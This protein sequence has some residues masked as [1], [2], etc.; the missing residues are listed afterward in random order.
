L[1]GSCG[2]SSWI[3]VCEGTPYVAHVDEKTSRA[4]PASSIA[5]SR[6]SVPITLLDQYFRGA[7]T[8]SPT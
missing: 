1:I 7:V 8:D 2:A 5:A 6:L 4:I 3:G